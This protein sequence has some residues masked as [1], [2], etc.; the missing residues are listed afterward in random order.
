[1]TDLKQFR[2]DYQA[3]RKDH[4]HDEVVLVVLRPGG[5]EQTLNIEPPQSDSASAPGGAGLP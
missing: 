1:V 5:E 3:F 4:P 2:S